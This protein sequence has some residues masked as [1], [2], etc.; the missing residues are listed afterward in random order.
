[1]HELS[2]SAAIVDTAVKHAAGRPVKTVSLRVGAL[3]QVVPETLA[4]Y[5]AFVAKGSVCEG[6]RL[7][8]TVLPAR[9][10]CSRCGDEWELDHPDFRC[11]ACEGASVAIVSG[12][13]LEVESIDVEE[14]ACISSG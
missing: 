1:M 6:A 9:L 4:F 10:R 13:E 8:Q 2:L 7:E 5:F 11:R 14:E 12:N 3:R